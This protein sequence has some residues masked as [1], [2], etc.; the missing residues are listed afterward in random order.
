MVQVTV[1]FH[2]GE[3]IFVGLSKT[4]MGAK[5]APRVPKL[6][7]FN[8]R[9]PKLSSRV[10]L[11]MLGA[12]V[13]CQIN[14]HMHFMEIDFDLGPPNIKS[15]GKLLD[16]V[17]RKICNICRY[18]RGERAVTSFY[19]RIPWGQKKGRRRPEKSNYSEAHSVR[20]MFCV[21][22]IMCTLGKF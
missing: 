20:D 18:S 12:S 5:T 17:I 4:E 21:L 14:I 10:T 19:S 9:V 6:G 7:Y 16:R 1:L 15:E 2:S 11:A 3:F 8:G 22:S 13:V